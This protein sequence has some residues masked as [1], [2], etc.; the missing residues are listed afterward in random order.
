MARKKQHSRR[1]PDRPHAPSR[2]QRIRS[3]LPA[4]RFVAVFVGVVGLAFA[5]LQQPA[6]Q[7]H[8]V[9]PYTAFVTRCARASLNVFG[10]QAGGTGAVISSPRFSIIVKNVCNGLEVTAIYL[11]AVL[12]FPV[13]WRWR[14]Y[15]V[16]AGYPVVFAI[17]IARIDVLFVLGYRAPDLFDAVHYYYAQV[18]VIVVVVAI[19]LAWLS[20]ALDHALAKTS[21]L[22]H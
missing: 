13:P 16:L 7:E 8:V 11:A 9:A 21:R 17:N 3:A 14:A 4:A 5:L 15:G 1:S 6:F 18:V 10:A 22:S 19:W 12:A 20:K 2:R